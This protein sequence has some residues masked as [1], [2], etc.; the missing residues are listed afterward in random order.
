MKTPSCSLN[1]LIWL[2]MRGEMGN[3][4]KINFPDLEICGIKSLLILQ[5]R[6]QYFRRAYIISIYK[7]QSFIFNGFFKKDTSSCFEILQFKVFAG[8]LQLSNYHRGESKF[9]KEH[10]SGLRLGAIFFQQVF[11][12]LFISMSSTKNKSDL[13]TPFCGL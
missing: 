12:F 7:Y 5:F 2:D 13:R 6:F 9:S 1:I 10:N 8:L 4:L 11:C 3:I